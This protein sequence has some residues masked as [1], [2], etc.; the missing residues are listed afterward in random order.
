MLFKTVLTSCHTYPRC[1]LI[2]VIDFFSC[3]NKFIFTFNFLNY[4]VSNMNMKSFFTS[5]QDPYQRQYE[6]LRAHYLDGLSLQE[7]N[8]KF[9]YTV[10][11]LKKLRFECA[12]A[13][14][15]GENPFFI[16]RKSGP[17]GRFT[18]EDILQSVINLRKLNHSIKDIQ[19]VLCAQGKKISLSCIDS[20]LK[21]EGF[22]P[23]YRRTRQE[24]NETGLPK[25]IA[26]PETVSLDLEPEEFYTEKGAGPLIFLPLLEELG[27]VN[28]IESA[29][30]PG[31]SQISASSYVLSF[32]ALKL[33]GNHR[34]AHDD[35]WNL[36]RGLGLF[37]GLN[38]LPKNASMSSYS[39]R[40][41]RTMNEKFLA[42]LV[43][44]FDDPESEDE[45]NLD[46]KTI[47]HWGD[48]SVL[49]NNWAGSKSK[50]I[51]SILSLIVQKPEQGILV[52]SDAE[53]KHSNQNAAVLEFV[54]F[55]KDAKGKCPKMLVFDSKFTTYENLSRLNKDGIKFL[56][57]R[58]RG[59]NLK[60]SVQ[61]ISENDWI[62]VKVE[63]DRRK[64]SLVSVHDSRCVIRHYDGEVRQI[65]I[66]DNG[67][68]NPA[69]LI[70][71]DLESPIKVLIRKYAR[72]W[73]VEQEIAEQVGFFHLN[74]PSSSI[75]VKVDFD[76]TLSVLAHN[77]YRKLASHLPG[78][79]NCTVPTLFRS[80]LD[81][82]AHVKIDQGK[83]SVAL[84]KK[85]H[86]PILL[87]TLWMGRSSKLSWMGTSID[88]QIGTVS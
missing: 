78:F 84:K 41:T 65:I 85:T 71:N 57:L 63:G 36:D 3:F 48:E 29:G 43:S 64:H 8:E 62:K 7:V 58:R 30:Y 47:P 12:Q 37:A 72:R 75:V 59:G 28:A 42:Q 31:T 52:Y 40:I 51:K 61:A 82:G 10:R 34:N 32:L 15:K 76:L 50:A 18:E 2:K 14:R 33:I 45:F 44:A 70:T 73:L 53:I 49:E 39:Y 69:F 55:W 56:T 74:Q 66:K 11:Y 19:A 5:T 86:M 21:D 13:V 20:I 81:T 22:A 38:V 35:K 60:K 88:Y 67:R 25:A 17:K 87:S 23:L 6:A 68:E 83:I 16:Q 24:R 46:F 54:D 79:E 80:F 9:G 4:S 27:I 1:A 26:I 77:L